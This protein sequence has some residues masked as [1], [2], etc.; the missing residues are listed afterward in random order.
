M[1]GRASPFRAAAGG[2]AVAVRVIPRAR[3]TRIDGIVADAGGA[4]AVKVAVT[5]PPADG[6]ANAA[7]VALLAEAWNVPKSAIEVASGAADR[8]KTVIV[9]GDPA[10]VLARLEAWRGTIDG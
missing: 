5:A 3:R 10:M 9:A 7:V 8:R 2:V 1:N 6:K 4:A